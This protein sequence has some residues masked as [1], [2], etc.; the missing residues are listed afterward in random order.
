MIKKPY[1]KCPKCETLVPI[2]TD[3]CEC[4]CYVGSQIPIMAEAIEPIE[5]QKKEEKETNEEWKFVQRCPNC[6]KDFFLKTKEERLSRCTNCGKATIR[7]VEPTAIIKEEPVEEPAEE[8]VVESAE[9]TQEVQEQKETPET[10]KKESSWDILFERLDKITKKDNPA[11]LKM[12]S[13]GRY[14]GFQIALEWKEVPIMLGREAEYQEFLSRDTRVSGK[15][16]Q[17]FVEDGAWMIRDNHSKNSTLLNE[18]EVSSEKA[19]KLKKGDSIVLG[20]QIDSMEFR[21]V[22]IS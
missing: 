12:E 6:G 14:A 18:A 2:Q 13:I 8:S 3:T 22:E 15:H 21:V 9:E 17:I 10:E 16:C 1:R 11:K 5:V 20:N 7:V 19:V 4:G